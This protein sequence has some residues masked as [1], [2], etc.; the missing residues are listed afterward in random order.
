MRTISRG[1]IPGMN[2]LEIFYKKVAG[3]LLGNV[4]QILGVMN[5]NSQWI[6]KQ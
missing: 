4:N 1:L 5:E 2:K 6:R 3:L